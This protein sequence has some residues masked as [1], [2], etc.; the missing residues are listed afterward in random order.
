MKLKVILFSFFVFFNISANSNEIAVSLIKN[1][2]KCKTSSY[3]DGAGH[4]TIGY[5]FKNH[6]TSSMSCKTA[7]NILNK[8]IEE[9]KIFL[10]K[11]IKYSLTKSQSAAVISLVYNIGI[12]SFKNSALLKKINQGKLSAA[13]RDF[14][15][16]TYIK[17]KQSRGL[18]IRRKKE[19]QLFL[20]VK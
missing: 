5:G 16:W 14:M 15:M 19:Q 13:S 17:K 20:G 6:S 18:L 9:I 12:P 2:E 3:I 4:K 10:S 11:E 1:I 7:E 8:K